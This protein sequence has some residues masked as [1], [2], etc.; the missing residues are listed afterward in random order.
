MQKTYV[1]SFYN[2]LCWHSIK[3]HSTVHDTRYFFLTLPLP[4]GNIV[5][6]TLTTKMHRDGFL[7]HC[8]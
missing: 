1:Q 5:C 4:L 8:A 2:H 3:L 7:A 6:L